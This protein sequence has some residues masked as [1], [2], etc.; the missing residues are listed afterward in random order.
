MALW[1]TRRAISSLLRSRFGRA[2]KRTPAYAFSTRA[3]GNH[4]PPSCS[5]VRLADSGLSPDAVFTWGTDNYRQL[6]HGFIR[7]SKGVYSDLQLLPKRMEAFDD[8]SIKQL[9]FGANHNA[10]CTFILSFKRLGLQE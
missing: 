4:V 2:V 6:G 3:T 8:K 9:Q 7:K 1:Q 10:A 5:V